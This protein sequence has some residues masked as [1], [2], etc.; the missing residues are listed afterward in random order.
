VQF[1]GFITGYPVPEATYRIEQ[2]MLLGDGAVLYKIRN[3]AEPF[4]RVVAD[5]DLTQS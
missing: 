1:T 3:E 2:L 4:D 5:R